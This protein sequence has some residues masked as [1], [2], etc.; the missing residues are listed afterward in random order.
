MSSRQEPSLT[1]TKPALLAT[2]VSLGALILLVAVFL[3]ARQGVESMIDDKTQAIKENTA[4][5]RTIIANQ[6]AAEI[7][8]KGL[9]TK[10]DILIERGE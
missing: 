4:A 2:K 1:I 5:I 7:D 10:L 6:H 8:R 9:E 3:A